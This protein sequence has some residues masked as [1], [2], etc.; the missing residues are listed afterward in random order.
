MSK[1]CSHTNLVA[2]K[3][4]DFSEFIICPGQTT[5]LDSFHSSENV[6]NCYILLKAFCKHANVSWLKSYRLK[7]HIL[8]SQAVNYA[9]SSLFSDFKF[10]VNTCIDSKLLFISKIIDISKMVDMADEEKELLLYL[11]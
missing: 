11:K 3:L 1:G 5:A 9:K 4:L 2:L 7:K 6:K 8:H 10:L